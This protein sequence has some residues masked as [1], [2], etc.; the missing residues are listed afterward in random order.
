MGHS[1]KNGEVGEKGGWGGG[2]SGPGEGGNTKLN[3]YFIARRL[4]FRI[5]VSVDGPPPNI[6]N[7]NE[8]EEFKSIDFFYL[9]SVSLEN[10]FS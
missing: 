4:F 3:S 8:L 2:Y 10:C 9:C 1:G 6:P 5:T 7:N